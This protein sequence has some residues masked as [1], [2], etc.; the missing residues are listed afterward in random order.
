METGKTLN[1]P[2]SLRGIP[3][4]YYWKTFSRTYRWLRCLVHVELLSWKSCTCSS[5]SS[6]CSQGL[7]Y[8]ASSSLTPLI[9][10][11]RPLPSHST[12]ILQAPRPSLVWNPAPLS[13]I[14]YASLR[15]TT[16]QFLLLVHQRIP[17]LWNWNVYWKSN[18]WTRIFLVSLN[19]LAK[20]WNCSFDLVCLYVSLSHLVCYCAPL[21]LGG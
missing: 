7:A 1:F 8:A 19:V 21:H 16:Q 18:L 11:L 12:H 6:P 2:Y 15:T 3:L 13:A 20:I 10:A 17:V 9:I 14:F 4:L 5:Y